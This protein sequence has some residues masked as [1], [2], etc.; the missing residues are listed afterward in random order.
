MKIW[1]TVQPTAANR[2]DFEYRQDMS[3]DTTPQTIYDNSSKSFNIPQLQLEF[4][5]MPI[6]AKTRKLKA[7]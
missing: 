4:S 3:K 2:G 7:V 1:Y 5:S 6:T